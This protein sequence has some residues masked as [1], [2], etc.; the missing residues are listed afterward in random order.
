MI[1][2]LLEQLSGTPFSFEIIVVDGG[3][4]DGTRAIVDHY[5]AVKW[6]SSPPGRA[7]QMNTGAASATGGILWFLH[8][9]SSISMKAGDLISGGLNSQ[10]V[11]GSF[12]L[13]FDRHNFWLGFYSQVSKFN[14]SIF[15][16]GDQGI[17]VKK[18]VFDAVGGFKDIPIMEDLDFVRR[19]KKIGK[20]NK[21]T[22]PVI[23]SARR[24][25]K[26][27]FVKQEIRNALLVFAYCIGISTRFLAKFYKY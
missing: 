18:E 19:V 15:T 7:I 3:S 2:R 23:T 26:H 22:Y 21:L 9:D 6:I 13:Q 10:A 17:F 12:Y 25:E 24:F 4:H 16:Y 14:C 1:G 8:A 27:G 11:A 20:F 5:T